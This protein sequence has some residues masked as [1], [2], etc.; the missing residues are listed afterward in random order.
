MVWDS[1]GLHSVYHVA[2]FGVLRIRR[3]GARSAEVA[4]GDRRTCPP[5]VADVERFL[6]AVCV[7]A[8]PGV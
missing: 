6:G 5:A 3:S 4:V 7:G 1:F 2:R 8:L